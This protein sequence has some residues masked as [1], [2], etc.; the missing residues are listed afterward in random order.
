[1]WDC[2]Q[3]LVG[4]DQLDQIAAQSNV[5][6]NEVSTLVDE[7]VSAQLDAIKLAIL[8]A[9]FLALLG[10]VIAQRLPTV[11]GAELGEKESA[12]AAD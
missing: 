6:T 1:M 5:P 12:G 4:R 11:P 10:L 3:T 2:P 9:I 8:L 7:Y